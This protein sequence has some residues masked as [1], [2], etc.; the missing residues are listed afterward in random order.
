MSSSEHSS[1]NASG[2]QERR[3]WKRMNGLY[4]KY[5]YGKAT[6]EEKEV[7]NKIS[8]LIMKNIKPCAEKELTS[9]E[10][11][12]WSEKT[13]Q[14]IVGRLGM[15]E[16]K[17]RP[18]KSVPIRAVARRN[19][20]RYAGIAAC[21]VLVFGLS[22]LQW[23]KGDT[24]KYLTAEGG[25]AEWRYD[26]D[27]TVLLPDGT[28]VYLKGGSRL[29]LAEDF[30]GHSRTV[31]LRGQAFF[32][33][34]TDSTRQFVVKTDGIEAVVHGTSFSV[35]AY[36]ETDIRQVTVCSGCVEVTNEKSAV[37]YGKYS[38]GG[39]VTYHLAD[40]SASM[41]QV[42]AD[43]ATEWI[44]GEFTLDAS[45]VDDLKMKVLQSFGKTLVIED[46]AIPSDAEITFSFRHASPTLDNVMRGVC[47][48]YAATYRISGSRVIVVPANNINQE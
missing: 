14:A 2:K 3:I 41:T 19:L 21:I 20:F 43:E 42:D 29:A 7:V 12:E 23:G 40:G 10:Q 48:V 24:R 17:E 31:S 32:D 47:S 18:Q 27:T 6:D 39:Q 8:D 11:E 46:D 25:N 1:R 35:M 45:T 37:T 4:H 30:G 38:R 5:M 34:A 9:E 26:R 33:V 15:N 22:C 28:E 16:D 13:F 44:R 36:P